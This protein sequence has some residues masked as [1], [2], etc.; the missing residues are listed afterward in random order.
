MQRDIDY[1]AV[2]VKTAI[3]EK[4][5][6]QTDLQALEVTANDKTISIVMG[7]R[8]AEG[9]RDNLLAAL[10]KATSFENLWEVLSAEGRLR[11]RQ[12]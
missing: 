5:D 10:R 3:V 6:R 12:S 9:T 4:F 2:A 11:R 7:T 1:A 8:I